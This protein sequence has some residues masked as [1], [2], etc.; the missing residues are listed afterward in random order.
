MKN[1]AAQTV[2]VDASGEFGVIETPEFLRGARRFTAGRLDPDETKRVVYYDHRNSR[3]TDATLKADARGWVVVDWDRTTLTEAAQAAYRLRGVDYGQ[4]LTFVV[5]GRETKPTGEELYARL[6]ENQRARN[7]RLAVRA[8]LHKARAET[9]RTSRFVHDI[10]HSVGHGEERQQQQQQEQRQTIRDACLHV[11][12]AHGSRKHLDPLTVYGRALPSYL[13]ASSLLP[14]LLEADVHVSPLLMYHTGTEAPS[15]ERAF[16]VLSRDAS[17][18]AHRTTV[19][20]CAL[21]EVWAKN[22]G[23]A[24]VKRFGP[25][26]RVTGYTRD[27]RLLRGHAASDGD[28]L[29]GTYLCGGSLS[30]KA[31]LA[32]LA[33]L[34]TRYPTQK[35]RSA[36]HAIVKCLTSVRV[37]PAHS[38]VLRAVAVSESWADAPRDAPP[39]LAFVHETLA[40][41]WRRVQD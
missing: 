23:A 24:P 41:H 40:R 31:Q 27:G 7:A 4:T 11:R 18:P 29:F 32:L 12:D 21:V 1:G 38:G 37:M 3:G 35:E 13:A 26:A 22:D 14:A 25:R 16:A 19:A 9:S 33:H 34:E 39:E 10:D 8:A 6:V 17:L 5:C 30:H 15:Y 2:V 28:V 36:I 20:V